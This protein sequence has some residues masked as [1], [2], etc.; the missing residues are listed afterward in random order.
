LQLV[1]IVRRMPDLVALPASMAAGWHDAAAAQIEVVGIT[2]DSRQV[3]HGMIFVALPGRRQDGRRFIPEAIAR[4]AAVVLAPAGTPRVAGVRPCAFI[5]D[6]EPR[7]RLAR[8]AALMAGSQPMVIAAVTGTNGKTSTVEFLRQLWAAAGHSAASLG[9]LG[10]IAPGIDGLPASGGLTTADPVTLAQTMAA[11]ARGGVTRAAVE[12]S[13]HGLDQFRLDGLRLVAGAFTNLS[14]D[15]LDYHGSLEAYRE[16]K[17]RLFQRMLPGRAPVVASTALDA[18]SMA[19]LRRLA[20]RRRLA[21]QVVGAGG[22]TIDLRRAVPL[23]DGQVLELR[24]DGAPAEVHLKLPGRFQADNALVAAALARVTGAPD[25]VAQMAGLAGV[26]G[27]ME[28]VAR[29]GNGAAVYV[30]FAHTPDALTTLLAALRPHCAGRLHIVFGAGGDRDRGKRPLMGAAAAAGADVVLVT[31]DNPRSE[32]AGEI[33]AA[34]LA[35]CPGAREI[36]DRAL[37]IEVALGG[38]GAGDVLVVAG[39][40]HET[41][42]VIGRETHP[43]DDAAVVRA[44]VGG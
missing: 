37:A 14:R 17:L 10:V 34:I 12:A 39:K 22:E 33:R 24:V 4:G 44:L 21:L 3:R 31:D 32:A 13:S 19:T 11:L 41:G 8:I 29:L 42:Q 40:G 20:Q 36:G 9:T 7:Q 28:L 2:S 27:R 26:R 25:A 16:A 18:E 5:E 15:H 35:A 38:L 30:D 23:A 1:D 6:P 43:F